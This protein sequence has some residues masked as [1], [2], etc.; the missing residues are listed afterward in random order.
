MM[1]MMMTT[2]TTTRMM[3]MMMMMMYKVGQDYLPIFWTIA[4]TVVRKELRSYGIH[5]P[6]VFPVQSGAEELLRVSQP[7]DSCSV[8]IYCSRNGSD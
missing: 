8:D 1:M 5:I 7:H 3:M 4:Y 6:Y 2:T